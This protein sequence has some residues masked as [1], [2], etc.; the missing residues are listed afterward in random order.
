M[1]DFSARL[2]PPPSRL[3]PGLLPGVMPP[4]PDVTLPRPS[5][6]GPSEGAATLDGFEFGS[7]ELTESHREQ[8]AT[9]A[10]TYRRLLE[11]PPGGRVRA[12]G[13]TDRVG[14]EEEN[15]ALG[16]E[17]S[18]AV[19]D[20]LVRHGLDASDIHTHSLGKGVPVAD[21]PHAEPR[22]RRVELYFAPNS[23]LGLEGVLTEGLRRPAPLEAT[24]PP[25]IPDLSPH[26]IDYCTLFPEACDPNRL[27][28]SIYRPIP[29]LPG[30]R[31]PSLTDAIWQPIDRALERGLSR[32]G[33]SD[34]WNQRLRDAAR[35]GAEKGA[36]E[37]LDR[38]MDAAN[39]TGATRQAVS[40]ALRAA[41][42]L[43]IPFR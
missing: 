30:R 17:R 7:A 4:I 33:L 26:R 20:E 6:L 8:I 16:Q 27:P 3:S 2:R 19:R 29:E 22:N 31:V 36:T 11:T 25:A 37:V 38:A 21:T 32:L 41:A 23:G 15:Q 39:L 34:E 42:Q 24:S 28:P 12:V 1:G 14:G 40:N 43:E 5:L 10:A 18:D 13:H 9:L 35:A